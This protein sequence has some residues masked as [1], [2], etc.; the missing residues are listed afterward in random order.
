MNHDDPLLK[1]DVPARANGV[2]LSQGGR[3][4]GWSLYVKGGKPSYGY[5]SLVAE[6]IGIGPETRFIGKINKVTLK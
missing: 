1:L 4:G 2:I 5:N 6:G 3:F